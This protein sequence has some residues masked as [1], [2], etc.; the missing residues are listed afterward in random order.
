MNT[1][2]SIRISLVAITWV[3]LKYLSEYLYLKCDLSVIITVKT[4]W[5]FLVHSGLILELF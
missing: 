2:S 5:Q 1:I 3:A 4:A